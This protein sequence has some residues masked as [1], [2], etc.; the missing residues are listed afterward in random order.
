MRNKPKSWPRR[1]TRPI[2]KLKNIK[3][4]GKKSMPNARKSEYIVKRNVATKKKMISAIE[5]KIDAD[6]TKKVID[7]ET[8]KISVAMIK[9]LEK[10]NSSILTL[11]I[12]RLE[13]T[14]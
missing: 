4:K 7:I 14:L 3:R 5:R 9:L 6:Y 8:K 11:L 2:V 12:L 13:S 1:N 10:P